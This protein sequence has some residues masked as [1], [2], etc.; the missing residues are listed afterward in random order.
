M[1]RNLFILKNLIGL[2]ISLLKV[3][4]KNK[5]GLQFSAKVLILMLFKISF[6]IMYTCD[7]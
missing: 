5:Y 4:Q 7:T 2:M 3:S 6:L 1:I